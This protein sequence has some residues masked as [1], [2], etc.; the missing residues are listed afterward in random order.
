MLA[1]HGYHLAAEDSSVKSVFAKYKH[2]K[3]NLVAVKTV[4]RVEDLGF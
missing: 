1:I 4:P 3:Y 2:K